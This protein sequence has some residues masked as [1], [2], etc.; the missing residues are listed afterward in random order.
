MAT[1]MQRVEKIEE[2]LSDWG[3]RV[4]G[5]ED[6]EA[7]DAQVAAKVDELKAAVG[8]TSDM[9]LADLGRK[10]AAG[11]VKA[12]TVAS[13]ISS[14]ARLRRGQSGA[15]RLDRV[16]VAVEGESRRLLDRVEWSEKALRQACV[17]VAQ[18]LLDGVA[19]ELVESWQGLPAWVK[20]MVRS[21]RYPRLGDVMK[22][23][24]VAS[25]S[26][27]DLEAVRRCATV[28][29]RWFGGV[30]GK[31]DP[32]VFLGLGRELRRGSPYS[33]HDQGEEAPDWAV[34]W[35]DRAR[36]VGAG[37]RVEELVMSGM[38]DKLVPL[39]DPF[40]TQSDVYRERLEAADSVREWR[41]YQ[42]RSLAGMVEA[43]MPVS[44]AVREKYRR[45]ESLKPAQVLEAIDREG[46][47]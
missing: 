42:G 14:A 33:R 36:E 23:V 18:E 15:S 30:A 24:D 43:G 22:Y 38:V 47:R 29:G 39:A 32:M 37:F 7:A 20:S 35:T 26:G 4:P 41:N 44:R 45:R 21:E 9:A 5:R 46:D 2:G 25:V 10:F 40:G 17:P 13:R 3:I 8:D 28:W 1:F 11:E 16:V 27:P 19:V 12:S 34:C 31:S 6:L